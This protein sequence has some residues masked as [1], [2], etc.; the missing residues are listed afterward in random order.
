MEP[1]AEGADVR[2]GYKQ[3]TGREVSA[4]GMRG[5]RAEE[6]REQSRG[7]EETKQGIGGIGSFVQCHRR[8]LYRLSENPIDFSQIPPYKRSN[9]IE[10]M[11]C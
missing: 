9:S 6:G 11:I 5:S 7:R 10:A 2:S 4:Y 3:N 8:K 1:R